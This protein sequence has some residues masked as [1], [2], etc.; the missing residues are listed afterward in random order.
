MRGDLSAGELET[1]IGSVPY[2]P[3]NRRLVSDVALLLGLGTTLTVINRKTQSS[4]DVCL[5]RPLQS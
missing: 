4:D 5:I 2:G 3:L 1:E